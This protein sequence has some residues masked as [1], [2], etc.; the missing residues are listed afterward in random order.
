MNYSAEVLFSVVRAY[1]KTM[2]RCSFGTTAGILHAHML[3]TVSARQ[4]LPSVC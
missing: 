1:L 2:L 4:Y 3:Q